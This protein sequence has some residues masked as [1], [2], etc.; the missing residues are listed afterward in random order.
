MVNLSPVP[1]NI[2]KGRGNSSAW[3]RIYWPA[4]RM[5][6]NMLLEIKSWTNGSVLYFST[7]IKSVDIAEQSNSDD[8]VKEGKIL[9]T[10]LPKNYL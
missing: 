1:W 8:W 7:S 9:L 5:D 4:S 3:S 2:N 10:N 6:K